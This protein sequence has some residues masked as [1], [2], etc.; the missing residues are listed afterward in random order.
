MLVGERNNVPKNNPEN[1]HISKQISSWHGQ[2]IKRLIPTHVSLNELLD[3]NFNFIGAGGKIPLKTANIQCWLPLVIGPHRSS[4]FMQMRFCLAVT[5]DC[6]ICHVFIRDYTQMSIKS[7]HLVPCVGLVS[8]R[9]GSLLPGLE[10]SL[11]QPIFCMN[12]TA[13]D[14]C[15]AWNLTNISGFHDSGVSPWFRIQ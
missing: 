5:K 3:M 15:Q 11:I 7:L 1:F 13:S 10:S 14:E 8:C 6:H 4:K 2:V 12:N 9:S